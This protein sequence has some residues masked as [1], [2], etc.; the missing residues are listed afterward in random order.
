MNRFLMVPVHLDALMVLE[1]TKIIAALAE[2]TGLPYFTGEFDANADTAYISENFIS[3]PFENLSLVLRPGVHLHWSLPDALTR[4]Q[5][6]PGEAHLDFPAVPNRWLVT[7]F[8][9]GTNKSW[10]VESDYL[11]PAD[12]A[13]MNQGLANGAISYP[14]HSDP[15]RT[16]PPFRFMGRAWLLEDWPG[17][18]QEGEYLP[19]LTAVGYGEP[20]FA[21]LYSNCRSVFGFHDPDWPLDQDAT[22]SV[23]GWYSDPKLDPC[24]AGLNPAGLNSRYGWHLPEATSDTPERLLCWAV[25]P[26]RFA[27]TAG[28]EPLATQ[29]K[30]TVG[31][32]ATEAL[33][34]YLAH[35]FT[36]ENSQRRTLEDQLE[37][38]NLLP[39][40]QHRQVDLGPKFEEAR[41]EKEFEAL[42]GGVIWV[43]RPVSSGGNPADPSQVHA[44]VNLP[45]DLAYRLDDLNQVQQ[46]RDQAIFVLQSWRER[47]YSDWYRYMLSS[48]LH[49]VSR[50]IILTLTGCAISSRHTI[51]LVSESRP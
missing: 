51:C 5:Q 13:G 26:L 46:E 29:V 40:L 19:K 33:S 37:A 27:A 22:Y 17:E 2:F 36:D 3:E 15:T 49:P 45:L 24:S 8:S 43:A 16:D 21:A 38:L 9:N 30:V 48:F 42:D 4:G 18:R 25:Q 44:E 39:L 12:G 32:T 47:L 20:T 11:Y 41:H 35:Y 1:P 23:V 10:I 14:I 6:I 50:E 34:A 7:R 31:N 28:Q